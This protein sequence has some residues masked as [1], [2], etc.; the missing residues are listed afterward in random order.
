MP[1][2]RLSLNTA[3]CEFVLGLKGL[4]EVYITTIY[5]VWRVILPIQADMKVNVSGLSLYGER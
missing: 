3:S 5:L 4:A 1:C 2:S